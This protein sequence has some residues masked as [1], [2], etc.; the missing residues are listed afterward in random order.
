MDRRLNRLKNALKDI[1]YLIRLHAELPNNDDI[2]AWDVIVE[3][4]CRYGM[5]YRVDDP[6]GRFVIKI[7]NAYEDYL[8][9]R[10][11]EEY[12]QWK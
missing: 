7:L 3:Q 1:W 4:F 2:R 6:E 11:K 9:E 12:K 8:T 5:K 10:A